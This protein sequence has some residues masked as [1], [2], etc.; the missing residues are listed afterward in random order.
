MPTTTIP[1]ELRDLF[2]EPAL[3]QV[4]YLNARG[5]IVTWQM[6]VDFDGD[7]HS[8]KVARFANVHRWRSRS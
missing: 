6:W 2:E 1:G 3:A 4:T 8:R 5:Q 7:H